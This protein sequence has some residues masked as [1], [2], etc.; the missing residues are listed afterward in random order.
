MTCINCG[1]EGEGKFCA[2]C[3]QRLEVKRIT[4]KEAWHDFWARIYGFDGMFPRTFKDLTI[5]P[6][7]ASREFIRGNRARYY[8]PVGYYFLMIT[9]FL[10]LLSMIG[11]D[12]VDY[13]SARQK[14]VP[15]EQTDNEFNRY[16]RQM[17]S[18]NLKVFAFILVPFPAFASRYLFFRKQGMNFLEHSIPVF[19]MLGHWYWFQMIEAVVFHYTGIT[20]GSL[21]QML[22]VSIYLGFGYITFV[23]TQPKWKTFLKG[24]SIYYTGFLFFVIIAV[25][26]TLGWVLIALMVDPSSLDSIRPSKNR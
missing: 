2:N 13:I 22:L 11:L 3:G 16:V 26:I 19:Y 12:Y 18:D 7:F 20:M 17:I 1:T 25:L 4:F 5:R 6:G 23:P 15:F 14:A 21:W 24:A 10:L 8:G 9:L